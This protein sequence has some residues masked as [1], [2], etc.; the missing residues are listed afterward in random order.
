MIKLKQ[1]LLIL[2]I[3]AAALYTLSL[4]WPRLRASLLYLPVDTA[5]SNYWDKRE[6]PGSQLRGLQQR[7]E[8]S[9]AI[10]PHHHYWDGLSFL[11]YLEGA[12]EDR[13]LYERRQAFEN[14]INAA[15]ASLGRA[16]S[17]PRAWL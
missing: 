15:T 7:A 8:K 11:Y 14:A 13:P 9:I 12:D 4:A 3:A 5:I 10:Y 6:T 2:F 17:Q 16:P 1:H